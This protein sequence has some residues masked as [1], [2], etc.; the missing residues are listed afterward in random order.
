[1]AKKEI[2]EALKALDIQAEGAVDTLRELQ[3][4][5]QQTG[6]VPF[7][8]KD[9][10]NDAYR[11]VVNELRRSLNVSENRARMDRFEANL[12][13]VEGDKAKLARERERMARTLESRRIEIRTYEN[14][15]GFLTSK[16]KS[17]ES[18]VNEFRRKI[19]RLK[20]DIAQIEERMRLIDGKL[21]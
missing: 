11:A 9:K 10:V 8:D 15:L 21:K 4:K 7:K 5:W 18:M 2:I 3:D 20:E 12:S 14:N 16:S 13:Q 17:G 1:M 19:E 6:H